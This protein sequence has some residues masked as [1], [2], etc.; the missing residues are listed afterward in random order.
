MSFHAIRAILLASATA[1][2]FGLALK[3]RHPNAALMTVE[4]KSMTN[5]D[6]PFDQILGNWFPLTYVLN[7]LNR[8]MGLPDL[9]PFVL[10]DAAIEKLR[11][12]HE[13]LHVPKAA[14]R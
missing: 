3:P 13:V 10:S 5:L 1:T 8:G 2:S 6:S 7:E 9:Y 4:P 14:A 11:F 12:V